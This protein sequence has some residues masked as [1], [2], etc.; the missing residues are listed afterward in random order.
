VHVKDIIA[1]INVALSTE[2]QDNFRGKRLI[3]SSGA[4][5]ICD[6]AEAAVTQ[7]PPEIL[8][9]DDEGK[10]SLVFQRSKI[11]SPVKLLQVI[12]FDYMFM[13]PIPGVKPVSLGM[14]SALLPLAKQPKFAATPQ[15]HDRQWELLKHVISGKWEGDKWHYSQGTKDLVSYVAEMRNEKLLPSDISKNLCHNFYFMDHDSGHWV[16][17]KQQFDGNVKRVPL[18]RSTFNSADELRCFVLPSISVYTSNSTKQ[19]P[20]KCEINFYYKRQRS[21]LIYSWKTSENE[22]MLELHEVQMCGYRCGHSAK[23][24]IK[25]QVPVSQILAGLESMKCRRMQMSSAIELDEDGVEIPETSMPTPPVV[26]LTQL[27]QPSRLVQSFPDSLVMSVPLTISKGSG[28]Q[29][30]AGCRHSPELFRVCTLSYGENG[31]AGLLEAEEY[32]PP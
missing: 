5:R 9:L 10:P 23:D 24:P 12:G 14:P 18:S 32:S 26:M 28:C 29:V 13:P 3:V 7:P 1:V 2:K 16:G 19:N 8:P 4:Y 15:A 20:F 21:M 6:L 31:N 17:P 27:P 30:V 25:E 11:I 22:K